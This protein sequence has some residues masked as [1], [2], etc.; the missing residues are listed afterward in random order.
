[1]HTAIMVWTEGE[2]AEYGSEK[3][4]SA[5]NM[6]LREVK[7]AKY[8]SAHGESVKNIVLCA[9]NMRRIWLCPG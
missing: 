9:V 5:W 7:C 3:D 1:M 6:V 4:E 8:G 2:G